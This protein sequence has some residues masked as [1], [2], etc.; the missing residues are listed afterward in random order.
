[1]IKIFN[2]SKLEINNS[3][4]MYIHIPFCI[5]KCY[6]C[7]FYSIPCQEKSYLDKYVRALIKEIQARYQQMPSKNIGSIYLGGGTPSL[8]EVDQLKAILQASRQ[9]NLVPGVEISIEVNPATLTKAK[10]EGLAEVGV[11]RISIGVQS[12]FDDELARLGRV[13][14]S[15]A[16]METVELLHNW[17]WK[18]FNLDLIY[19]LP[20]QSLPRWNQTLQKAV[21]CEP[22][23]LSVYLLQLEEQ[24]PM[25]RDVATGRLQMLDED[26]EWYMYNQAMEY[27]K[28]KGYIQYEIS[29][30]CRKG[31]ECRHN[32][33]YWQGRE[34]LG[35]GA[36][37][38]SYIDGCRILNQPNLM[39]YCEKL[40]EDKPWPVK[41]LE[42]ITGRELMVDA[43]LL[44]LRLNAG[45]NL[46]EF[47]QRFGVDIFSEFKEVITHYI[48]RGL[49][50][51]ENG[52]LKLTNEGKFLSNQVLCDFI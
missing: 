19:G 5:K 26:E 43:L 49:L 48:E 1:M 18:N 38:V 14:N 30:F 7:D 52:S 42:H 45:I 4:G 21:A 3:L 9:F 35:V 44:G 36:G 28:N 15:L 51:I 11:N 34:Y 46:M 27:L 47:R 32:L 37:A 2:N 12:F 20:G 10:L 23:H 8:L 31:R 24:T 17:G 29:N 50:I 22:A 40:F 41:E 33:V 6:Y 25:G 39:Q 16:V 13:H